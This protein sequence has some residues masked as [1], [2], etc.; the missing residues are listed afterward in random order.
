MQASTKMGPPAV[1]SIPA[2]DTSTR[3]GRFV[4]GSRAFMYPVV[5]PR[6]LSGL[7]ILGT[8]NGWDYMDAAVQHYPRIQR[9]REGGKRGS[10]LGRY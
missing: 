2:L 3:R 7:A 1:A 6:R 9:K 5:D 8:C 10:G 4:L